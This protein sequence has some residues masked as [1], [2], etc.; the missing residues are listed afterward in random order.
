MV[1][2]AANDVMAT[3]Q[4]VVAVFYVPI[5]HTWLTCMSSVSRSSS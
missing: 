4:Y 2:L 5:Y 3:M 1:G